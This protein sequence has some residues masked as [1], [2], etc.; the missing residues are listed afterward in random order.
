V[1]IKPKQ[2]KTHNTTLICN[3]GKIGHA[4]WQI[5]P[6]TD[7]SL[8]QH[9]WLCEKASSQWLAFAMPFLLLARS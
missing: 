6:T 1:L 8:Q 4:M 9:N 3:K 7:Y 2:Q 5:W